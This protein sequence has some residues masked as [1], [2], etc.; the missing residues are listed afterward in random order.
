GIVERH[1]V[2]RVGEDTPSP[3]RLAPAPYFLDAARD[4]APARE[5]HPAEARGICA[6]IVVHPAVIGAIHAELQGRIV[7]RPRAEP[8]RGERQVD[9][10]A[11]VVEGLDAFRWIVIA[12]RR[13][14]ALLLDAG[15]TGHVSGRGL[16]RLRRAEATAVAALAL[17][18]GLVPVLPDRVVLLPLR[19]AFLL[20]LG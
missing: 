12:A 6:A 8:S 3:P 17:V 10:H 15:E 13:D 2:R 20:R 18:V 5:Q 19:Q 14:L 7:G 9:V 1:A 16:V 4:V 11:F